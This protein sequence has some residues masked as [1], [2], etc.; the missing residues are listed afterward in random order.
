MKDIKSIIIGFLMATCM[1]LFMGATA[2][3]NQVGRYQV[4]TVENV[5]NGIPRHIETIIDTKTG[6]VVSRG[7]YNHKSGISKPYKLK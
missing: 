7:T 5:F 4:S 1:F 3:D 6:K 2:D